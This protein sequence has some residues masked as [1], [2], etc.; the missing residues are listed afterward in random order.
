MK[1]QI[2]IV[3]DEN[4]ILQFLQRG[5]M[6]KGFEV[7][8]ATSGEE[9]LKLASARGP[10][11][12]LLD[13]MLPD[14]SGIEVC[15]ALRSAEKGTA[16]PILMLT[17]KDDRSDK[18]M[19]LESGADDYI[20]K[21]F[22]FEELVARIRAALRRVESTRRMGKFEVGDLVIDTATHSVCRAG[23]RIAL[24]KREYDLLELLAQNAGRVLTK[25]RIFERIWGY[26]NEAGLEVIKVYIN[27]LRAK[28]NAGEK[29]DLIHSVRGVG[30]LLK[31]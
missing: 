6:Y 10:D 9:A 1:N 17:A 22:D 8:A 5:L 24:T 3:E 14:I 13:I 26:D 7:L 4:H 28:L 27:T 15:R 30:Y 20:T 18:I 11:L 16:L 2:L 31:A 21:P 19:G 23:E 29:V 12:V 25:E